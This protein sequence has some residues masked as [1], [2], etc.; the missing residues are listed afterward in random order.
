MNIRQA[1]ETHW[2][3]PTNHRGSRI[4]ATTER[5]DPLTHAWDYALTSDENHHAAADALR[6]KL[7]WPAIVAGGSTR[8]GY[9][10]VTS[11][12]ET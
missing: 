7:D 11:T 5:R 1:I 10:F 3:G 4:I 8:K 9:A 6:A 12:L 2:V